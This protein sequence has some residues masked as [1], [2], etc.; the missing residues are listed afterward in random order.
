MFCESKIS[1]LTK[2]F[3]FAK[4]IIST[5]KNL[6]KIEIND[7]DF[8]QLAMEFKTTPENLIYS[9]VHHVKFMSQHVKNNIINGQDLEEA[10]MG[11]FEDALPGI[12]FNDMIRNIVGEHDFIID[13]GDYDSESGIIWVDISFLEGTILNMA[14]AKLQFGNDSGIVVS[15]YLE[16]YPKNLNLKEITNSLEHKLDEDDPVF[17]LE[18][19][20]SIEITDYGDSLGIF[21]QINWDEPLNLPSI[22]EIDKIMKNIKNLILDSRI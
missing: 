15:E 21:L 2:Y 3:T 1:L 16:E 4:I 10:F 6:M 18:S 7:S 20:D 17:D 22:E 9:L 19:G 12:L 13:D 5:L 8:E 11:I 14:T